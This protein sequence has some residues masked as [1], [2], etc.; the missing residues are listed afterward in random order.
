MG[1]TNQAN[2]V[3]E[4]M[5][6]IISAKVFVAI[7]EQGSMLAAAK[8]LGMSRSMVTRHLNNMENWADARLF[9]RSTRKLTLT[10]AGEKTLAQCKNLLSIADSLPTLNQDIK[11]EAKGQLRISSSYSFANDVIIPL[12]PKFMGLHPKVALDILISSDAVD[13]VAERIDLAIRIS[14]NLDPNLIFRTF[15]TCHSVLCATPYYIEQNGNIST[16][17]QLTQHSCLN[18]SSFNKHWRFY[19]DDQ[20]VDIEINNTL[21]INNA[22]ALLTATLNHLGVSL[23]PKYSV[24]EHIKSGDLIELLPSNK[25]DTLGI[26]G[27]YKSREHMPLA[28]RVFID[29]LAEEIPNLDL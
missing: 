11:T 19:Q 5:D 12:L 13:L 9:H 26:Y 2:Q 21:N 4:T 6:K 10:D 18:Y 8:R 16:L 25:A 24:A 1:H 22:K 27:V 15:G 20:P 23:L 29:F 3:I 28:L 14:N 7:V 17:E